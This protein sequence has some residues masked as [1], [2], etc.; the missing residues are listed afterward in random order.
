M[1]LFLC[2]FLSILGSIH[3]G[4]FAATPFENK[5]Y[6]ANRDSKTISVYDSALEKVVNTLPLKK[7]PE[8][9][10]L[11]PNG[12]SLFVLN[13]YSV[14]II[15]TDPK[16]MK[17]LKTIDTFK[18]SRIGRPIAIAFSLDGSAA[19]I[20]CN[21]N[22][23]TKVELLLLNTSTNEIT[24]SQTIFNFLGRKTTAIDFIV[25]KDGK[26]A[27]ILYTIEKNSAIVAIELAKN[28]QRWIK[29]LN[30]SDPCSLVLTADGSKIYTSG[31]TSY[32]SGTLST[33]NTSDGTNKTIQNP[34]HLKSFAANLNQKIATIYANSASTISII[35]T[36]SNQCNKTGI[37]GV[38]SAIA[39]NK[40]GSKLYVANPKESKVFVYMIDFPYME[41]FSTFSVDENPVDIVVGPEM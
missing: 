16:A 30:L 7:A 13:D 35:D 40:E 4:L 3:S 12:K 26:I 24:N 11:T 39:L 19:Y 21:Q 8:K 23:D 15:S 1:K 18:N 32:Y 38:F 22:Q 37:K 25:S 2:L 5:V 9:L 28:K 29:S 20:L 36:S 33:I 6:I 10:G 41:L 31:K 34:H 27:Y 14:S 17:V